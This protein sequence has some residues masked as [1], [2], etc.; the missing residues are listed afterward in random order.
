MGLSYASDADWV[1]GFDDEAAIVRVPRT[2]GAAETLIPGAGA[3]SG[4]LL[5]DDR[6]LF[7]LFGT[8]GNREIR[9]APKSGGSFT[10]IY[11]GPLNSAVVMDADHLYFMSATNILSSLPKSGGSAT[12]FGGTSADGIWMAGVDG[13]YVHYVTLDDH[14]ADIPWTFNRV[15]KTGGAEEVLTTLA[16]TTSDFPRPFTD[17]NYIF[18]WLGDQI[19][20]VSKTDGAVD[21][22]HQGPGAHFLG[23]ALDDT[24]L[25]WT[26]SDGMSH[27]WLTRI[28]KS[29]GDATVL[30]D[31]MTALGQGMTLTG[32]SVYYSSPEILQICR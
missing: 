14:Q 9:R 32:D 30:V 13:Q 3:N 22:L 12:E 26:S 2:G 10:N 7:W 27:A 31:T 23:A 15:R 19:V 16:R 28:D 8:F 6:Y 29:G 5:V 20:R 21:I 17:D 25:Y 11:V 24:H 4:N 1:Y 18:A